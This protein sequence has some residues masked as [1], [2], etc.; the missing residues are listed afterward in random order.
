MTTF[1]YFLFFY[2]PDTPTIHE[3]NI[4]AETQKHTQSIDCQQP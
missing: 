2:V 4:N 3:R 1:K